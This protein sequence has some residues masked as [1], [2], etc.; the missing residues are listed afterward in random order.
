LRAMK[1]TAFLINNARGGLVDEAALLVALQERWIGGAAL[2]VRV[3][4]P[5]PPDDALLRRDD[6]LVTPHAAAFTVEAI[7]DL[8]AL[9][10]DYLEEALVR[11]TA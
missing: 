11:V 10:I 1:S 9:V 6:V 5:P 2:D 4:E 3:Q 8:R 7:D